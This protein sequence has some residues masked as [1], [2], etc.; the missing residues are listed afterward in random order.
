M[1]LIRRSSLA[2]SIILGSSWFDRS[3]SSSV[4]HCSTRSTTMNSSGTWIASAM[5]MFHSCLK[6]LAC[7]K[8]RWLQ[9][10]GFWYARCGWARS[11]CTMRCLTR[12][13]GVKKRAEE[14][15]LQREYRSVGLWAWNACIISRQKSVTQLSW[16]PEEPPIQ[17]RE[18]RPEVDQ[19]TRYSRTPLFS[20][21]SLGERWKSWRESLVGLSSSSSSFGDRE[22]RHR[23]EYLNA[24]ISKNPE[25]VNIN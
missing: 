4:R 6:V 19:V 5:N 12:V 1:T 18:L 13:R 25:V 22:S 15:L 23:S 17:R 3:A 7:A 9:S 16:L 20:H 24:S 10:S 8:R 11:S 14:R 2:S 21:W